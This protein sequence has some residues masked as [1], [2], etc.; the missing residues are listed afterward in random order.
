AVGSLTRA[1][2]HP[3]FRRYSA[4]CQSEAPSGSMNRPSVRP[5]NSER[6]SALAP[7]GPSWARR[8]WFAPPAGSCISCSNPSVIGGLGRE[9]PHFRA[10]AFRSRCA[11]ASTFVA[12]D[13]R[14]RVRRPGLGGPWGRFWTAVAP[15]G[16]VDG[17]TRRLPSGPALPGGLLIQGPGA[18]LAPRARP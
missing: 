12:A 11:G 14:S 16:A 7:L 17:D 2:V 18:S 15:A 10:V 5:A 13:R 3:V 6:I 9:R 4:A 1:T 8:P